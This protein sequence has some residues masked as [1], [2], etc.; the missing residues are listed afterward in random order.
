MAG[1]TLDAGPLIL[2]DRLDER[3]RQYA[4]AATR[5]T[6]RRM[7]VPA[8][9]LAQAWRSARNANLARFLQGCELEP[10]TPELARQAGVLC[11]LAGT[12]DV[13]DAAVMASAAGRGDLVL[14]TDYADLARL[15]LVLPSVRVIGI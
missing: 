6:P 9:A 12:T 3:I 14:T 7:T 4:T 8:P 5:V 13:V 15:A 1:L 2:A 10:M 11:G